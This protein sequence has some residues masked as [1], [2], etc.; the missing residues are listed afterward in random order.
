M[1]G[2]TE[3]LFTTVDRDADGNVVTFGVV[4]DESG[5]TYWAF[6]H[7]DPAQF[8]AEV[9]RWLVHTVG[10]DEQVYSDPEQLAR[11]GPHVDWLHARMNGPDDER[12]TL[13]LPVGRDSD[14]DLFPVTRLQL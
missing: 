9:N 8:I 14:A 1:S 6:G 12:F 3:E 11:A 4:E 10:E 5:G 13:G 7:V 2:D